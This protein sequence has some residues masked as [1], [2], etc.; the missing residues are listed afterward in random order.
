MS[1]LFGIFIFSSAT[2]HIHTSIFC[3]T[4]SL[5]PSL[6]VELKHYSQ[7]SSRQ[8]KPVF[9]SFGN[10][11]EMQHDDGTFRQFTTSMSSWVYELG[12]G[13]TKNNLGRDQPSLLTMDFHL[14][15]QYSSSH[16]I[17][18]AINSNSIITAAET[19]ASLLQPRQ[20]ARDLLNRM[21]S[22]P[23]HYPEGEFGNQ[24]GSNLHNPSL[25]LDTEAPTAGF[26]FEFESEPIPAP[27]LGSDGQIQG[28]S[29]PKNFTQATQL[30]QV[31]MSP[32]NCTLADRVA[33]PRDEQITSATPGTA[34]LQRVRINRRQTRIP[35]LHIDSSMTEAE[36][37]RRAQRNQ[38]M[39][40]IDR[41]ERRARNNASAAKARKAKIDKIAT[42]EA[43]ILALRQHVE[44][45]DERI[46]R[47][48]CELEGLRARLEESREKS[49]EPTPGVPTATESRRGICGA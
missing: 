5:A 4:Q 16:K 3:H 45:Q 24:G 29:A 19:S 15:R 14:R 33:R 42:Q 47:L 35:W 10:I 7:P 18:Q 34:P 40:E 17:P 25:Q 11:D 31:S 23:Q 43:T 26:T 20:I 37:L 49:A 39:A 2:T 30:S 21:N 8:T 28:P 27:I 41:A 22:L 6:R 13:S 32:E 36:Q 9:S 12:E 1:K 48:K 38:E 46:E 44:E